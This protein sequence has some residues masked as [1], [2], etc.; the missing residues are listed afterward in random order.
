[1]ARQGCE[2]AEAF[3]KYCTKVE[4]TAEWGG[5]LELQAMAHALQRCI[6]VHAVSLGVSANPPT[7]SSLRHPREPPPYRSAACACIVDPWQQPSST[8]SSGERDPR[9]AAWGC[10]RWGCRM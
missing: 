1:V 9:G 10:G 8:S 5:H 4:S 6:H 3:D 7:L 2:D